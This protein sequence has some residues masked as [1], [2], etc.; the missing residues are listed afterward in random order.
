MTHA[1][2]P[3]S[4][5]AK[6]P[7]LA[8]LFAEGAAAADRDGRLPVDN[9]RRLHESG[10][11]Q[12]VIRRDRGGLGGGLADA[13]RAVSTIAQGE[14]ATALI[15]AMHYIQHGQI[16][17]ESG[18]WPQALA[19]RLVRSSL[20][21]GAL[22]N[23]AYVEPVN[24]SLAHGAVP[25]T[26]ARR[27][28]D[29]WLLSG[30]KKY[31]TGIDG[32][33]WLR[34]IGVTDEA[35]PRIGFF[36][37]PA[38]APGIRVERTWNTLGMRS[39]SSEDVIFE[40]VRL[41]LENFFGDAPTAEGL[42]NSPFDGIWYLLLVA[43]VYHGI[44]QAARDDIVR[45]AREHAPGSLGAPLASLPRFQDAIG[46]IEVWQTAARRLL[47]SIGR[48]YDEA[49]SAGNAD[50]RLDGLAADASVARLAVIR[51]AIQVTSLALELAGNRGV[52]RDNAFERYHRDT[53]AARAHNPQAHLTRLN[54]GNRALGQKRVTPLRDGAAQADRI[55]ALVP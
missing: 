42:R 44:A 19:D 16:A 14:S 31:V 30:H 45:F 53:L 3:A 34:T 10:L 50:E 6:A 39:T 24:G 4:A 36:L 7:E 11:L 18:Y 41:P 25:H 35:E 40:D 23:A 28:G 54:L 33:S 51:D 46:Q 37:V 48:D 38:D 27:V 29:H 32:L 21:R 52:S 8:R 26:R 43:A 55:E 2:T 15:L 1:R 20:E 47:H 5:L 22:I 17:I 12:L 13:V 9:F 49:V